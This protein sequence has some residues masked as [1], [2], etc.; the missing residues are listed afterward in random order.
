MI[1]LDSSS[2]A[3]QEPSRSRTEVVPEG[4]RPAPPPGR[5]G[6][7]GPPGGPLRPGGPLHLLDASFLGAKS[8]RG[9]EPFGVF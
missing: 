2:L 9:I 6:W 4:G 5:S 8:R 7:V 1:G 3:V